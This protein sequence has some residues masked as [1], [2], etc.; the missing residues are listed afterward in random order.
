MRYRTCEQQML[1]LE[2]KWSEQLMRGDR[3]V[4]LT[5]DDGEEADYLREAWVL[6]K[7]TDTKFFVFEKLVGAYKRPEYPVYRFGYYAIKS[8]G[9]W[10][11][12]LANPMFDAEDWRKVMVAM[13]EADMMMGIPALV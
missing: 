4:H 2:T 10:F 5:F 9:S 8:D 6:V 12:P 11:R 3:D 7:S 1:W 13:S